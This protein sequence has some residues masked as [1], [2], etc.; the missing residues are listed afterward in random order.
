MR[1]LIRNSPLLYPLYVR[2][3]LRNKTVVFPG[4][5]TELHLTGFPRSGNTYCFNLFRCE[6]PQIKIS[7]HIHTTA[8]IKLALRYGVPVFILIR[9]PQDTVISLRVFKESEHFSAAATLLRDYI[10]Y[11]QF[12][13]DHANNITVLRFEDTAGNAPFVFRVVSDVLNLDM[14]D[15]EIQRMS[16]S[17][18]ASFKE[19]EKTKDVRKS[20]LPNM[21]REAMK[22]KCRNEVC[23]LS[24]LSHATSL[25]DQLCALALRP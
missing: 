14:D 6:L 11:H 22:E 2:Y 21:E 3:V 16:T 13:L 4:P 19:R 17:A 8:S 9:S 12:V 1:R 7:T 10:E 23:S 24:E 15:D 25:Y 18:E 20:S 5:D